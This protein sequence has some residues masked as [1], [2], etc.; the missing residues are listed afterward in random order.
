MPRRTCVSILS[1]L[2][3]HR[4]SIKKS[5]YDWLFRPTTSPESRRPDL[6]HTLHVFALERQ[7]PI[8]I[9]G[10]DIMGFIPLYAD[11]DIYKVLRQISVVTNPINL[12]TDDVDDYKLEALRDSYELFLDV[13]E[14]AARH[15]EG[16]KEMVERYKDSGDIGLLQCLMEDSKHLGAEMQIEVA[17]GVDWLFMENLVWRDNRVREGVVRA[18]WGWVGLVVDLVYY[19][20]RGEESSDSDDTF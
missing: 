5:E 11:H 20:R 2:N 17:R 15:E 1:P 16:L 4:P 14:E 8:P 13:F 7:S 18:L 19:R 12:L 10:V 9:Y 6:T 3:P